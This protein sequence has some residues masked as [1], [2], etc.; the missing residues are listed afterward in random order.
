MREILIGLALAALALSA[1]PAAAQESAVV[2]ETGKYIAV[3]STDIAALAQEVASILDWTGTTPGVDRFYPL[4]GMVT[5]S[6]SVL[7]VQGGLQD[8]P[9][10][11]QHF[12]LFRDQACRN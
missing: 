5:S 8:I 2:Y 12:T 10:Y 1:S 11:V 3:A 7:V 6:A 9:L 4:G